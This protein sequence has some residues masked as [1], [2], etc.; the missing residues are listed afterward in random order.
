[1][2]V[3]SRR[4]SKQQRQGCKI[5]TLYVLLFALAIIFVGS[6]SVVVLIDLL[7]VQNS[8]N[9]SGH[10]NLPDAESRSSS[11]N[12]AGTS[13]RTISKQKHEMKAAT[14]FQTPPPPILSD[15]A[16]AMCTR[17]LYHTL[18]TTTIVLPHAETFVFTGDIDDLWLRDSAAQVHPYMV[19]LDAAVP[20]SSRL[21]HDPVL[22]RVV[23][24]LIARH[25]L[26]IH[27]DPYANA[28][29]IDDTYV[30]SAA[31]KRMGRHD[32]IS[33]WNYELDSGCY[34]IRMLYYYWKQTSVKEAD[35]VLATN[36]AV[37]RAVGI[38][39]T[40]WKAEQR[41]EDDAIAPGLDCVNC[42]RPY[43]YP[44]L[45]RTGKGSETNPN[46]GLTWS[47][48]RASDDQQQYGYLVPANMMCVTVLGYVE[49]L[50]RDLWDDVH[51]VQQAAEL[52]AE[53]QRGIE[54]HAVVHHP[55]YGP[56]YAYEVDGL[57]NHLLMDDANVPSLLSL[58][59]LEYPFLNETIYSNTRRFLL[60]PD[61]PTFSSGKNA[62][63][64]PIAGIGSP[65]MQQRIRN[66][67]WPMAL[68]IEAL[69]DPNGTQAAHLAEQLVRATAGTGWM[70]E[71]ISVSNPKQYTRAWFCWADALY[72]EL[73]LRVLRDGGGDTAH[74]WD[75]PYTIK[76][77]RDTEQT[78]Q[79]L[80]TA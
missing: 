51:M 45:P 3:L 44:G 34:T 71:S 31:Q 43:R 39:L 9:R 74:C 58:P 16:I 57:G 79:S 19:P 66:N 41:H 37:K 4:Q 6:S 24:G 22:D 72:A 11:K 36:P 64:G 1:M 49:E 15:D 17:T 48:F 13:T 80:Q 68:A 25:A 78:M 30:F 73:V 20:R 59:Y 8:A 67:V 62:L 55:K 61:N 28:F 50:A 7:K 53:I 32:L 40:L 47:G 52:K 5:R 2:A 21:S 70:H 42:G 75:H 12:D 63:T 26:Y 10:P 76:E 27:H 56:I 46:A 35:T 38:M 33:T 18:A 69:T 23:A 29:R 14:S 54:E 77:W 60:S 65:H